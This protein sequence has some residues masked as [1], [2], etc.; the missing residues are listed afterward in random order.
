MRSLLRLLVLFAVAC[1]DVP[2]EV[3]Q[4]EVTRNTVDN[5]LSLTGSY[6]TSPAGDVDYPV[7][8]MFIVDGSG[9]LQFSDQNRQRA[10]A[11]EEVIN[12]LICT[13]AAFFKIV[14]FNSAV[15]ATPPVAAGSCD[16]GDPVFTN[17]NIQLA[18]GITDLAIADTLT[19]YQGALSV[20]YA[21]LQRDMDCVRAG[22]GQAELGRTKYALIF[23]SDGLPDPQCTVGACNDF[24]PSFAVGRCNAALCGAIS[25]NGAGI[26]CICESQDFLNCVLRVDLGLTGGADCTI[27]A[28][29]PAGSTACD[30]NGTLCCSRDDADPVM[31]G[32]QNNLF[33]GA[34]LV[35]LAGGADYNQP[36]QIL[37]KVV[38]I[39]ELADRYEVGE[40]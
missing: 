15:L 36:Y 25:Q 12:G 8:V 24:N 18:N 22:G 19:D 23:I 40:L 16:A 14:V 10:R 38:D 37:Q 20:A 7:K 3:I 33:G 39:M 28:T 13:G 29:C 6:C 32:Y 9:S 2:I 21:E 26:D 30:Y 35:E 5:E 27:N 34:D 11:V 31:A 4:P 1:S 17:D